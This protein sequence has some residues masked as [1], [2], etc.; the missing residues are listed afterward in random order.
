M[1]KSNITRVKLRRNSAVIVYTTLTYI[2][3]QYLHYNYT[4]LI[5]IS[6]TPVY[7]PYFYTFYLVSTPHLHSTNNKLHF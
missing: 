6:S 2:Y 7:T 3:I 4:I 1:F 5:S